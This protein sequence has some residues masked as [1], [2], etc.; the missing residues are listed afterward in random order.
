[1]GYHVVVDLEM[2]RVIGRNKQFP[3]ANEIIQIGAALLDERYEIVD[4]FMSY[5]KPVFGRIDSFIYNL[6]G[7]GGRDVREAPFL[8]EA[9]SDFKNGFRKRTCEPCRGV[10][11]MRIKSEGKWRLRESETAG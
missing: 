10:K 7:I 2:C 6:T 4:R 11:R 8:E 9:L 5:V 3:Y 1:M